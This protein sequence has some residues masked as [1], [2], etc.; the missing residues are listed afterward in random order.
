MSPQLISS[1]LMDQ[2]DTAEMDEMSDSSRDFYIGL[3]LA[4]S[5]SI[6]IGTSFVL[7]KKGLQQ[8]AVRASKYCM[9]FAESKSGFFF[10]FLIRPLCATFVVAVVNRNQPV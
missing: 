1:A 4:M 5:S 8:I 3:S 9:P 7:T 6:F 2:T 10:V